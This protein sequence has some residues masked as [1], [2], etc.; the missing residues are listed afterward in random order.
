M[1]YRGTSIC[2][3]TV[4]MHIPKDI[5]SLLFNSSEYRYVDLWLM[6]RKENGCV[7]IVVL[8][9]RMIDD[10]APELGILKPCCRLEESRI[11]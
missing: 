9:Q 2:D 4:R 11:W 10:Y 8:G 6:F 3:G 1:E 7:E 5:V